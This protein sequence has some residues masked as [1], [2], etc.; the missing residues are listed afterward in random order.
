MII[1]V[2]DYSWR[3]VISVFLPCVKLTILSL[4][5]PFFAYYMIK[6]SDNFYL[7]FFANGVICVTSV[8]FVVWYIGI[9]RVIRKKI[10]TK[11][12]KKYEN[13]WCKTR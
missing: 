3:E 8:L 7:S 1:K 11:I 12:F 13:Y 9:D 5:I 4:P 10:V 6:G 2:V